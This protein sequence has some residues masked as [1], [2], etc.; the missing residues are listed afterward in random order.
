MTHVVKYLGLLLLLLAAQQGALIHECSHVS[1][2]NGTE[3]NVA[4]AA[5]ADSK[6]SLCPAFAQVNT[7]AFSHSLHVPLLI[8]GAPELSAVPLPALIDTAVPRPRSRG[9]P[10]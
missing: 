4:A 10:V 8:R 5:V 2:V 7:P 3:F 1:G 9:P 6:C